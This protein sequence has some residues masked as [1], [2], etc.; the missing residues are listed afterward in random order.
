M[1]N[2]L[3]LKID[4][5]PSRKAMGFY[6]LA[7][8]AGD[9]AQQGKKAAA[10]AVRFYASTGDKLADFK[11]YKLSDL[12]SEIMYTEERELRIVYKP[13]PNIDFKA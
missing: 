5:Y 8:R 9:I 10:E 1:L 13:G 11:N 12:G 3:T 4:S 7:D 2:N 6:N